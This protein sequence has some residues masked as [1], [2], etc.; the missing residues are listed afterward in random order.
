MFVAHLGKISITTNQTNNA[1]EQNAESTRTHSDHKIFRVNEEDYDD[2]DDNITSSPEFSQQEQS[3]IIEVRNM[4]LFSL[5]TTTRKGFRL[6]VIIMQ[7]RYY[8]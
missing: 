6:Y 3:Y 1:D 4:N 2:I 7:N 5:D 8:S